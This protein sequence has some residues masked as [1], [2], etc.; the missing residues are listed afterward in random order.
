M[1]DIDGV[2]AMCIDGSLARAS[3]LFGFEVIIIS[4]GPQ[5]SRDHQRRGPCS[6][7][8][9]ARSGFT[10]GSSWNVPQMT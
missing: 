9:E 3:L 2:D 6:A 8:I 4:S 10:A 7:R 5:E 1:D